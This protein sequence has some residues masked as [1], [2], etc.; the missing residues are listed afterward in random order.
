MRAILCFLALIAG[1]LVATL[2]SL[3]G[4]MLSIHAGG[5]M[6]VAF[7]IA[8]L[9]IGAGLVIINKAGDIW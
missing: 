9:S 8:I 3:A 1:F 6:F 4:V 5:D 7:P 2:G